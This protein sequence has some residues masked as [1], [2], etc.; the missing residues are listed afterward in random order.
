MFY[1][2]L[3]DA[4]VCI[5][6][7][8]VAA[9]ALQDVK[10]F[11]IPNV[12]SLSVIVLYPAFVVSSGT[13]VDWVAAAGIA[14]A[15]LLVGFL[16]FALKLCGGGDAKLF[17]A[18]ALW[19]GPASILEFTLITAV[20]GGVI[21]VGLWASHKASFLVPFLPQGLSCDSE[22]FAKKPMPYGAAIAVGA[23]YVAFTLLR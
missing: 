8:L 6:A 13:A 11:T 17:A 4:T 14:S 7:L 10:N 9:A 16:L 3:S 5:F 20:A 23:V 21:A 22:T 12:Y 2:L 18:V 15:C 19:A 1:N